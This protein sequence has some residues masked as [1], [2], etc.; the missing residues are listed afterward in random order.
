MKTPERKPVKT[1]QY[2]LNGSASARNLSFLYIVLSIFLTFK[3]RAHVEYVI[4]L[5]AGSILLLWYTLTHFKLKRFNIKSGDLADQLG[6]YREHILKREK[7]ES[8]VF[9]SWILTIIPAV[10][11]EREISVATVIVFMIAIFL[12]IVLGNYLFKKVIK[13][14]NEL[15]LQLDAINR[16]QKNTL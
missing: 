11:F 8:T 6:I 3:M 9:F 13:E 4:P 12:V 10:L 16:D 7:F 14:L 5:V 1:F 2:L 15:E